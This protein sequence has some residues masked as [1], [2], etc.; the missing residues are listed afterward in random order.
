MQPPR[1]SPEN[2]G[3]PCK[4]RK[5]SSGCVAGAMPICEGLKSVRLSYQ[6]SLGV[7]SRI[8]PVRSNSVK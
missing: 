1:I 4:S 8:V 3:L 6:T 5:P 7:T 2:V